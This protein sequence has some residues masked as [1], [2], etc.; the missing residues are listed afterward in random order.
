[1]NHNDLKLEYIKHD[2]ITDIT[3]KDTLLYYSTEGAKALKLHYKM[4]LSYRLENLMH[5][6]TRK[7]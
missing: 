1:M 3:K 4:K 7:N 6:I 5:E 2:K